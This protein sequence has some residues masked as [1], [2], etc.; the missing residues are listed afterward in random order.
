MLQSA[1]STTRN[2]LSDVLHRRACTGRPCLPVTHPHG[3]T[4]CIQCP[5]C[6]VYVCTHTQYVTQCAQGHTLVARTDVMI[7]VEGSSGC[8][9][10]VRG[11]SADCE[12]NGS[13]LVPS[14]PGPPLHDKGVWPMQSSGAVLNPAC[15]QPARI[16]HPSQLFYLSWFPSLG[17]AALSSD[18]AAQ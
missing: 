9:G 16:Y 12:R 7:A 6:G 4:Q 10:S 8:H 11:G 17:Q 18:A 13:H 5:L 2:V 3:Y 1:P 14:P 15:W